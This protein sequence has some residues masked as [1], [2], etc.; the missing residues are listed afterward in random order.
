M[1]DTSNKDIVLFA[2]YELGGAAIAVHTEDVANKVFQYPLGRQRYQ[3]EKYAKYPDKERVAREL[4]RLKQWRGTSYVKGHVNIGARNDRI[5]GWLLTPEG[6]ERVKAMDIR[7]RGALEADAGTYSVYKA[8]DIRRRIEDTA[9]YRLYQKHKS[10][11]KAE[12]IDFT[13]MLYCLPDSSTD[14]IRAAFDMLLGKA[15]VVE[16]DD[17]VT[18]LEAVGARF[19]KLLGEK[20]TPNEP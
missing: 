13:D 15:K 19:A 9:C 17:L 4:R 8:E 3:W 11:R 5:D 10:L 16:A 18:F 14:K 2:L 6:V 7:I 20:D 1:A 12:D